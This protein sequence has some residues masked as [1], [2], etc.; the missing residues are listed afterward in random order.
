[1][2][3]RLV[4]QALFT[5]SSS[6]LGARPACFGVRLLPTWSA[7]SASC[8]AVGRCRALSGC[9]PVC[10]ALAVR[11]SVCLPAGAL[12]S[13]GGLCCALVGCY[14][15]GCA[16][17]RAVRCRCSFFGRSAI[18]R[19]LDPRFAVSG[20]LMCSRLPC[21]LVAVAVALCLHCSAAAVGAALPPALPLLRSMV[22]RS[23][24]SPCCRAAGLCALGCCALLA[25][26]LV[27]ARVRRAAVR[28]RWSAPTHCAFCSWPA[29]CALGSWRCAARPAVLLGLLGFCAVP[30][31]P[32]V[33]RGAACLP[34]LRCLLGRCWAVYLRFL[35]SMARGLPCLL[36]PVHDR[37]RPHAL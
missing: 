1:M 28:P 24:S 3:I 19:R 5:L 8:G 2:R 30:A 33:G 36:S 15:V 9:L 18:R 13:S 14:V 27:S 32:A 16:V 11:G 35:P 6:P 7:L 23:P 10:W 17:G 20:L 12:C 22:C 37:L 26:L 25:V 29:V 21:P 31:V 34:C 4:R